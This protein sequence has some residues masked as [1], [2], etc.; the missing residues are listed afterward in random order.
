MLH[1]PF[2]VLYRSGKTQ[3]SI[4]SGSRKWE[5]T[6]SETVFVFSYLK[7]RMDETDFQDPDATAYASMEI[8]GWNLAE[9]SNNIS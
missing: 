8:Q 1:S 6:Y 2:F 4:S 3:Y 5:N 9:I 7:S